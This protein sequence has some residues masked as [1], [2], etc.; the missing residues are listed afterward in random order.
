MKD[1]LTTAADSKPLLIYVHSP[2]HHNSTSIVNKL[3]ESKPASTL[4]NKYFSVFGLV[5]S[6][7]DV[8]IILNWIPS[9]EFPC[10]MLLRKSGPQKVVLDEVVALKGEESKL[11]SVYLIHEAHTY[12][13]KLDPKF[14]IAN[15]AETDPARRKENSRSEMERK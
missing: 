13:V 15:P 10:M 4:L 7:P 1:F 9:E 11:T 5:D 12:L 3:L 2:E 6:H 14:T 8:K